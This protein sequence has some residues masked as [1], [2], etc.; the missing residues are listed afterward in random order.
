MC[1]NPRPTPS[2]LTAYPS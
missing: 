1:Q 2:P